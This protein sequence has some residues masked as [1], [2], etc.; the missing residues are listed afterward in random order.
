MSIDTWFVRGN[1]SSDAMSFPRFQVKIGEGFGKVRVLGRPES[2][3]ECNVAAPDPAGDDEILQKLVTDAKLD[4]ER[5]LKG[6]KLC[7]F[8]RFLVHTNRSCCGERR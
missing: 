4:N 7:P 3:K 8:I 2:C 5:Q 6:A 1:T